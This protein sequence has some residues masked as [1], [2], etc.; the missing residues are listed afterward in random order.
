MKR[1]TLI[2]I[3]VISLIIAII[4][5]FYFRDKTESFNQTLNLTATIISS[6][7]AILTFI[8]ALFLF[9]KYG[10]EATLLEK[11]TSAVFAF[12]EELK[13]TKFFIYGEKYGLNLEMHN[14][15]LFSLESYYGD[16]LIF[17]IEYYDGLNK[18]LSISASP[19][20]P[21]SIADKAQGLRFSVLAFDVKEE[22]YKKYS[23][24]NL[25][26]QYK[27]DGK[28]GRFN[29]EDMTLFQFLNILD[30]IKTETVNW[31]KKNSNYAPDLNL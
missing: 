20:M 9:D 22:D 21:K 5:P 16:K 11:N 6:V 27:M 12:L 24:V 23:I 13:L 2:L 19:F 14:P 18:L 4:L 10:I 29:H 7:A 3:F 30:E 8:V 25:A 26:G 15:H 31:I 1:T 28:Y 17:P